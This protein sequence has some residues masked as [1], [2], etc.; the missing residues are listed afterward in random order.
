MMVRAYSYKK[1]TVRA[2]K[3][4]LSQPQNRILDRL[5]SSRNGI[6][7]W[8]H[9][10][11]IPGYKPAMRSLVHH[12]VVDEFDYGC[13]RLHETADVARIRDQGLGASWPKGSL[14]GG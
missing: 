7:G 13:F 10:V 9:V 5:M 8:T 2:G 12:G 3:R 4:Q 6:I 14:K 1:P 11:D